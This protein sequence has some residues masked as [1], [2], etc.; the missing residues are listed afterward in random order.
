MAGM[1]DAQSKLGRAA[2]VLSFKVMDVLEAARAIEALHDGGLRVL[3]LE[4]G[5]PSGGAPQAALAAARTAL[6]GPSAALGYTPARGLPELRRALT[7]H[8]VERYDSN[9]QHPSSHPLIPLPS[10]PP[11][12]GMED[13]LSL[14]RAST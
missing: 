4:V 2:S 3:H 6:D 11:C 9:V 5:E 12:I 1:G 14:G 7:A 13:A 8:Y 10:P